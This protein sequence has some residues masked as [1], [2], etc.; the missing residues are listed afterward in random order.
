M[1]RV[2][3]P[4]L[5]SRWKYEYRHWA[6]KFVVQTKTC[7]AQRPL[8]QEGGPSRLVHGTRC[9]LSQVAAVSSLCASGCDKL[10][11]ELARNPTTNAP[12][13]RGSPQTSHSFS[14]SASLF[15]RSFFS[16]SFF[17]AG[18]ADV[19]SW[20]VVP[21]RDVQGRIGSHG[22]AINM[23]LWSWLEITARSL[24]LR[25]S[26]PQPPRKAPAAHTGRWSGVQHAAGCLSVF[27]SHVFVEEAKL[28][29]P[30]HA[31]PGPFYTASSASGTTSV[32]ISFAT[33]SEPDRRDPF[34]A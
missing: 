24:S 6:P 10:Q 4:Y 21:H 28:P 20:S 29:P 7:S 16:A 1:P 13:A 32:V 25:P 31:N 12:P 2:A 22:I 27:F 30:P 8:F 23:L 11:V 5:R 9:L 17:C 15:E 33:S 26:L 14:L 18:S 3:T 34:S 19:A